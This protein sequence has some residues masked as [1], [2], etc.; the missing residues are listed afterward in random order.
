MQA[1]RQKSRL[2]RS[3][4]PVKSNK[5]RKR[6]RERAS[7]GGE[8]VKS[9]AATG[10]PILKKGIEKCSAKFPILISRRAG[11][12]HWSRIL[13]QFL[14]C[15]LG[16]LHLQFVKQKRRADYA[17]PDGLGAV[18]GIGR[19]SGGDQVAAQGT[20]VEISEDA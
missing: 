12:E 18:V 16:P 5:Y 9:I 17:E 3:L 14:L 19:G 11:A 13:R 7:T 20:D 10:S 4:S 8:W 2:H 15:S 1:A 6:G